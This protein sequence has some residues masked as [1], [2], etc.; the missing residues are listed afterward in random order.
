M[1]KESSVPAEPLKLVQAEKAEKEDPFGGLKPRDEH[2]F[3]MKKNLSEPAKPNEAEKIVEEK[4]V[5]YEENQYGYNEYAPTGNYEQNYGDEYYEGYSRSRYG[6][7]R[8]GGFR[9]GR[10]SRGGYRRGGRYRGGYNQV[11]YNGL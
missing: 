10:F 9:R 8:R 11:I 6:G 5:V 4:P 1:K 7:R 2:A 3:E